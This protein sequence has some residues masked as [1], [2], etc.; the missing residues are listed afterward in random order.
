VKCLLKSVDHLLIKLLFSFCLSKVHYIFKHRLLKKRRF[1]NNFHTLG[2][3]FSLCNNSLCYE[4]LGNMLQAQLFCLLLLCFSFCELLAMVKPREN[5]RL[6]EH[7]DL[8]SESPGSCHWQKMNSMLTQVK[9]LGGS[10]NIEESTS[11]RGNEG[12]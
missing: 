11:P 5:Q 12:F 7:R 2:V 1:F 4:K 10:F 6:T 3:L 8:H 9:K